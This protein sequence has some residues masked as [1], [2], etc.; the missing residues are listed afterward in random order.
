MA[1]SDVEPRVDSADPAVQMVAYLD[2]YR[3]AAARKVL[4]LAPDQQRTSLLPSGWTPLE[5]LSHL[6]HMEQRWFAWGFHAE[7]VD[8][9]WGDKAGGTDAGRWHVPDDVT[10]AD[11]AERLHAG[12]ERTTQILTTVPWSTRGTIGGRFTAEP[13]PT[14]AWIAFHVLQEYA[15]HVGHLDVARELADGTTGE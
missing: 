3:A 4:G 8:Q 13:T 14:L 1:V 10:A 9:P 2:Y 6:V 7:Q 11:L 15:R 12:G 5:L